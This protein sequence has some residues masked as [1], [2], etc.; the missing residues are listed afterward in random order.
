MVQQG[1]S[2]GV[3]R[4]VLLCIMSG[5]LALAV[6]GCAADPTRQAAPV[7]QPDDADN[8]DT[9]LAALTTWRAQEISRDVAAILHGMRLAHLARLASLEPKQ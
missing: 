1:A 8:D 2:S 6:A 4:T 3:R 7:D 5:T 9:L